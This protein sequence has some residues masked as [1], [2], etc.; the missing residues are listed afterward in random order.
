MIITTVD[1]HPTNT[2]GAHT[3][4]AIG[5]DGFPV[6][7]YYDETAGALKVAKCVNVNCTGLNVITTLHNPPNDVGRDTSIVV[8]SDGLPVIT[9]HDATIDALNVARCASPACNT[10]ASITN[11][12]PAGN[13]SLGRK[14]MALG[15]DGL[16]LISFERIQG[17][18]VE[19]RVLKCGNAAC[20][21]GNANNLVT[22]V[23]SVLAA[24][25]NGTSIA[26][27]ADGFPI[28]SHSGLR[29]S[30]CGDATCASGNVTSMLDSPP[31]IIAGILSSIAIGTDSLPVISHSD[32]ITGTLRVSKCGNI[33]C[34]N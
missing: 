6:I 3:S 7:A 21:A 19:I 18:G 5:A 34:T 8:G 27:G 31:G 32:Y 16:P 29:V 14:D 1:D 17:Q 13:A 26:I 10:G 25:G 9:Y 23:T 22:T 15:A 12:V 28:V 24:P 30:K 20:T 11:V 4:I 33:A 2:V